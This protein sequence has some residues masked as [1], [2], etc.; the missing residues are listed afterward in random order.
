[1]TAPEPVNSF[2]ELVGKLHQQGLPVEGMVLSVPRRLFD[3]L[4]M[5]MG[6]PAQVHELELV[7]VIGFLDVKVKIRPLDSLLLNLEAPRHVS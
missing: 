5:R 7:C 3:V 1:V 6:E 4:A 2:I